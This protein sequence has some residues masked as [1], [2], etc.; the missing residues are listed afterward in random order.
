LEVIHGS[1][2]WRQQANFI[3]GTSIK[4]SAHDVDSEQ[5]WARKLD[6]HLFEICCIPFFAYDLALGDVVE[7]DVDFSIRRV[8]KRSGRYV[9][10]VHFPHEGL[11]GRTTAQELTGLGALTEWYAPQLLAVDCVDEAMAVTA[12]AFLQQQEDQESLIYETGRSR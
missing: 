9:F 7:T 2:V 4:A 5:L 11:R 6:Q 3:I 12:A 1:P 8:V 10:R